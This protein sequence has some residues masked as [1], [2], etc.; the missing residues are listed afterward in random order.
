[1]SKFDT[2]LQRQ[3]VIAFFLPVIVGTGGAGLITADD[4]LPRVVVP[5]P[6]T[7]AINA[8]GIAQIERCDGVVVRDVIEAGR[9]AGAIGTVVVVVADDPHGTTRTP[10]LVGT[11]AVQTTAAWDA[12]DE[13][14]D[15]RNSLSAVGRHRAGTPRDHES[16]IADA[17]IE[18]VL[19]CTPET[20]AAFQAAPRD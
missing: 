13:N 12:I 1:M 17:V 19:A 3:I 20:P 7:H 6:G 10:F 18:A 16:L 11:D 2:L 14:P 9:L 5:L 4:V 8:L 15:L